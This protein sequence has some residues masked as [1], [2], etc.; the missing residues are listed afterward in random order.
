MGFQNFVVINKIHHKKKE[1]LRYG[2]EQ[3]IKFAT[4]NK[5]YDDSNI[6]DKEQVRDLCIMMSNTAN[7]TLHIRDIV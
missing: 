5:S 7:F 3:E 6:D 1:L 2:K 4:T